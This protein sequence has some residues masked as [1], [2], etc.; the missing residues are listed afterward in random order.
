MTPA[1]FNV[2]HKAVQGCE[3]AQ[4]SGTALKALILPKEV[5][6]GAPSRRLCLQCS[7]RPCLAVLHNPPAWGHRPLINSW[8]QRHISAQQRWR[9]LIRASDGHTP[10]SAYYHCSAKKA[11]ERCTEQWNGWCKSI[12]PIQSTSKHHR[13]PLMTAS[14]EVVQC[15][16]VKL[17]RAYP[18]R[19]P[20]AECV[21]E[22]LSVAEYHS[23]GGPMAAPQ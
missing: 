1:K 15:N 6:E 16:S 23:K 22:C 9:R 5:R 7:L 17:L 11:S 20:E 2:V 14:P 18:G 4:L 8:S 12:P 10:C 19:S 21:P 3:S 13:S